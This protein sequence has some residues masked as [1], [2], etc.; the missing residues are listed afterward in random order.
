MATA[1]SVYVTTKQVVLTMSEEEAIA[2]MTV[3]GKVIGLPE[4]T[5]RGQTDSV[6]EALKSAGIKP[7]FAWAMGNVEFFS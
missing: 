4:V 7:K 3:L 2:T 1:K 5:M 6:Y